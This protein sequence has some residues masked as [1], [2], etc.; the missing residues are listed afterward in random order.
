[1]CYFSVEIINNGLFVKSD[2]IGRQVVV[3]GS[4]V[5]CGEHEDIVNHLFFSYPIARALV[6]FIVLYLSGLLLLFIGI[7]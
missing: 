4:C 3:F 2:L 7:S 5:M 1:M 6:C